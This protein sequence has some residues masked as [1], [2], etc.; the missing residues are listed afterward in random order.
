MEHILILHPLDS[1]LCYAIMKMRTKLSGADCRARLGAST[2]PGGMTLSWRAREPGVLGE[3][4]GSAFRLHARTYYRNCFAPFFYGQLT[5]A[6]G[7]TLLE[8]DFRMNPFVRLFL[9]F[10]FSFLLLFG[11][12]AIIVPA[13]AHPALTL[14]RGWLF[15]I[16]GLLALLG[17]GLAQFGKWLGRGDQAVILAFLKSTLE[18]TDL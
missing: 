10:W 5:E 2:D 3:F 18:A 15:A 8:G 6:G 17:I 12:G 4:R 11:A 13:Q 16:L 1:V 9:V 7:G 14:S